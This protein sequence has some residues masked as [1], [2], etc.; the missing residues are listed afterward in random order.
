MET[1]KRSQLY[2][3]LAR[4]KQLYCTESDSAAVSRV[5]RQG[6]PIYVFLTTPLFRIEFSRRRF[7]NPIT[8]STKGLLGSDRAETPRV[9]R[10]AVYNVERNW[11]ESKRSETPNT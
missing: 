8:V 6:L 7:S 3:T 10:L 1:K 5:D 2:A 4:S 9:E 11:E